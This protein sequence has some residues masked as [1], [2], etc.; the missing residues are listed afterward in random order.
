MPAKKSE[1]EK[2]K[3][4]KKKRVFPKHKNPP[5]R[6]M[7]APRKEI[8]FDQLEKLCALQC[9]LWEIADWFRVSEDTIETRCKE[10]YG[11]TFSEIYKQKSAQGRI[12]LRRRQFL[13]AENNVAMAIWLGKQMLNQREPTLQIDVTPTFPELSQNMKDLSIDELKA[14]AKKKVEDSKK[15]KTVNV[16]PNYKVS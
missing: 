10:H 16:K 3:A 11:M 1:P 4:K 2:P 7:G 5:K 12:S 14:L 15:P 9:P 6:A 13:L 8:D